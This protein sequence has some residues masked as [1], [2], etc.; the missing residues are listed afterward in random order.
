MNKPKLLQSLIL[1]GLL[2]A[3][4]QG[5]VAGGYYHHGHHHDYGGALAAG[6]LV[7]GL[8]GYMISESHNHYPDYAYR[9]YYSDY[10]PPTT[11][12][13]QPV[14]RVPVVV[15]EVQ[16]SEFG[17]NECVMTREYTTTINVNGVER[18]AYGT[19][20]MTPNGGWILGKAKLMP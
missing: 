15:R 4:S 9:T 10:P 20:C 13:Y 5:V 7:G 16:D 6:L 3:A 19:R 14:E 2:V 11:V 1:S 17:G 18:E 8:F 12:V